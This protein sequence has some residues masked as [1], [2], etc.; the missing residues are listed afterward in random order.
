MPSYPQVIHMSRED[1]ERF[2]YDGCFAIIS[3]SDPG[4]PEPKFAKNKQ[5]LGILRLR[6]HDV[7]YV[8][9]EANLSELQLYD[10]HIARQVVQFVEAH[11]P[12]VSLI[13]CHC[14]AGISRSAALA[15]AIALRVLNGK[16]G[17]RKG[18]PNRRVFL[19]TMLAWRNV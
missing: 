3:I 11:L 15:G 17:A 5:L 9:P 13:L 19:E 2:I 7:D 18:V 4:T 1:A 10:E 14:E 6:L 8:P 16:S 12:H